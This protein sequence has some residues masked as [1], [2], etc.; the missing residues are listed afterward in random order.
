M[1]KTYR[2]EFYIIIGILNISLILLVFSIF[3]SYTISEYK[4]IDIRMEGGW[5]IESDDAVG[6][7]PVKNSSKVRKHLK[8]GLVYHLVTDKRGARV[9]SYP[10]EADNNSIAIMTLG[11]SYSWGHGIENEHTYT[12]IL[13]HKLGISCTNLA[14]ASYGTVQ[15]ALQLERN[16]DLKP[17]VIIYGFITDHIRRNLSP[18]APSFY[19]FCLPTAYVAF[20]EEERP[21][22]HP[23]QMPDGIALARK[24]YRKIVIS[25]SVADGIFWGAKINWYRLTKSKKI[26]QNNPFP[27]DDL[28]RSKSMKFLLDKMSAKANEIGAVLLV[29]HIPYFVRGATNPVPP[30]LLHALNEDI[31]FI[32]LAPVVARYY[33]NPQNPLLHFDRDYHPNPL[34]HA[35]IADEIEA[36]LVEE[37]I[38]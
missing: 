22:I 35:L 21:Y 9:N 38:F 18:C 25:D 29:V 4:A 33:S 2:K 26:S 37:E 31:L 10:Y 8:N 28:S 12:E 1:H 7:V 15:S 17:E 16:A 14:F 6:F 3:F 20:D 27:N 30:E 13:R 11:G 5:V 19:P 24:F 34:A 32:D 36:I 23:P